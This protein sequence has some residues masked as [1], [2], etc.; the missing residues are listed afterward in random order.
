MNADREEPDM[1]QIITVTGM[2]C[3]HCAAAVEQSLCALPDVKKARADH[4]QNRAVI[5]VAN[6]VP[7]QTIRQAVESAGF[8]CGDITLKKG[9][10]G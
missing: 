2:H 4:E 7:A 9:L 3:A 1:K 8:Q 5:T 10:L 6:E